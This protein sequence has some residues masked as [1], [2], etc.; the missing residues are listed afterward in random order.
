MKNK[1]I[2]GA[3]LYETIASGLTDIPWLILIT[4]LLTAW[5]K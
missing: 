3:Y 4:N 2:V 5:T 1:R